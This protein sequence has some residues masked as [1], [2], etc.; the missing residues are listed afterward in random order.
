M[1]PVAEQNMSMSELNDS[2]ARMGLTKTEMNVGGVSIPTLRGSWQ[3]KIRKEDDDGGFVTAFKDYD[4]I[5]MLPH[6]AINLK[7]CELL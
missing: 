6:A 4:L 3:K 5:R 7:Q 1:K 2:A